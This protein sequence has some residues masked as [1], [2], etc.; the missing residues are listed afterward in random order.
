M[1]L[2]DFNNC[3]CPYCGDYDVIEDIELNEE[4]AVQNERCTA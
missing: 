4:L 1:I 2:A 3:Y